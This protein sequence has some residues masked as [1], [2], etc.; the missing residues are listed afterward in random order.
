M[1][2][3]QFFHERGF[4]YVHTRSSPR[5]TAKAPARCSAYR[6]CDPDAPPKVEGKVDYTKDFFNKPAYLTVSGQLQG[7]AFACA[8]VASTPS[9]DVPCREL[10]HPRHLAEFWMIEPEMAFF[11]LTETWTSRKPSQADHLGR[12]EVLHGRPQVFAEEAG[13][14]Q[15]VV[16]QTRQRAEHRSAFS[17][18]EGVEFSSRAAKVGVPGVVGLDLQS[19]HERTVAE[20]YFKCPVILYGTTTPLKPFYMKVNDDQKTVERWTCCAGCGEIWR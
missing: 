1:S 6:P 20:Q 4:Y 18:T 3:H 14:Q 10:E 11:D 7:E 13:E 15:G 2:I 16:H 9:A 17:Y 8:L 19:E 12:A 5:A